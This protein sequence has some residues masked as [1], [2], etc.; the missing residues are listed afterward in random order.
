MYMPHSMQQM[1]PPSRAPTSQAGFNQ[2]P[3]E[4]STYQLEGEGL[5][6]SSSFKASDTINPSHI[7][8]A[9]ELVLNAQIGIGAE[10]KVGAR[11]CE[12]VVVCSICGLPEPCR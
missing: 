5:L 1:W 7:I 6:E 9:G 10:G 3:P 4:A 2:Q 11:V 12:F 8:T